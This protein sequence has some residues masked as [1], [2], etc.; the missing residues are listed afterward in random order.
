[1]FAF[2]PGKRVNMSIHYLERASSFLAVVPTITEQKAHSTWFWWH[3]VSPKNTLKV[4]P[5]FGPNAT[6]FFPLVNGVLSGSWLTADVFPPVAFSS[7]GWIPAVFQQHNNPGGVWHLF[8]SVTGVLRLTLI[9]ATFLDI[10]SKAH[11]SGELWPFT[12][13]ICHRASQSS[14]LP[15][16]AGSQRLVLKL[17]IP[18]SHKSFLMHLCL[19]P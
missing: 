14:M 16:G 10:L 11:S 8:L 15:S 7:L 2:L 1:M 18:I 12:V 9:K 5:L 17:D 6:A 19:F 3:S 4:S 13:P